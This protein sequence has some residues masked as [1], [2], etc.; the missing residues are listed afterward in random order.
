M[1]P[2]SPARSEAITPHSAPLCSWIHAARSLPKQPGLSG[3]WADAEPAANTSM[4]AL[5]APT[6]RIFFIVSPSWVVALVVAADAAG[7]TYPRPTR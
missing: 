5:I 6:A 2:L 4:V 7:T 1:S 3:L